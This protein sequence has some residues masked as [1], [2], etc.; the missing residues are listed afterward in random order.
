MTANLSTSQ[1][2]HLTN[3]WCWRRGF[4]AEDLGSHSCA[5]DLVLLIKLKDE[6]GQYIS[7]DD[8]CWLNGIW[9]MVYKRHFPLKNKHYQKIADITKQAIN[10]ETRHRYQQ[11]R[12]QQQRKA[13]V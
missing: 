3:L 5:D 7:N 11:Q 10:K 12:I 9:G 13:K 6:L 4:K 1:I 8:H 2:N